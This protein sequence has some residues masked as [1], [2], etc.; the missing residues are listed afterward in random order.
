MRHSAAHVM[1]D[2][3]QRLFPEAKVTIGPSIETGFYY[4]FDVSHP[5]REEDL[6]RIEE[7]MRKIIS[8][9]LPFER[10]AISRNEAIELFRQMGEP[11]KV[12]II[13]AIPENETITLYQHGKFVD[14]C[15][16]PHVSRTGEIKAVKLLSCAGAYWRGDERNK[17]LQ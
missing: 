11:Y 16:G 10:K 3:V 4:D 17:M 14:L 9:N 15:R 2:A 1:A 5:F 6:A 8:E 12:E 7:E 13:S